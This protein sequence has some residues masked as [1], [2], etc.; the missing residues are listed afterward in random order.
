LDEA[1]AVAGN[2]CELGQVLRNL[3]GNAIDA[4]SGAGTVTI[5]VARVVL[6][7]PQAQRLLM[8]PGPYVRLSVADDGRGIDP[9]TAQRIFDPFFTTKAI[10]KGTGLGLAIVR[11]IV[12]SWGGTIVLRAGVVRGTVFDVLL[13]AVAEVAPEC[14]DRTGGAAGTPLQGT[15]VMVVDDDVAVAAVI[16]RTLRRAGLGVRVFHSA[17][18]ALADFDAVRPHLVVSDLIMPGVDGLTFVGEIRRRHGHIPTI[19]LTGGGQGG[20]ATD[21]LEA[22][23]EQAGAQTLIFKPIDGERLLAAVRQCLNDFPVRQAEMTK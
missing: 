18:D 16:A 9:E 13:P 2:S 6:D 23:A 3:V 17:A 21:D 7:E 20:P 5:S 11:G 10:G 22:R 8:S 1:A 14:G 12:Q 4:M 15:T 19:V